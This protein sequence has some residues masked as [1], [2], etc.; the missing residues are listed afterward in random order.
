MKANTSDTLCLYLIRHGETK[1]SL[2]GRHTGRT[3]IPLTVNGEEE[4]WGS[5]PIFRRLQ[6]SP[7]YDGFGI[8]EATTND[9]Q[10]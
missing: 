5:T 10:R 8:T 7:T 6:R 9:M 2:S 4:A 3:D 1:W